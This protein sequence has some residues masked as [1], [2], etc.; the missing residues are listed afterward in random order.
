MAHEAKEFR[1][2]NKKIKKKLK[3]IIIKRKKNKNKYI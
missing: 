3:I 2:I 1:E